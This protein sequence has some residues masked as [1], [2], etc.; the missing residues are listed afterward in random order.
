MSSKRY[1]GTCGLMI[2]K[3][4]AWDAH[5]RKMVFQDETLSAG[6][7][8]ERYSAVMQYTGVKDLNNQPIYEG[9]VCKVVEDYEKGTEIQTGVIRFKGGAFCFQDFALYEFPG[10]GTI[11]EIEIIGNKFENP[12]LIE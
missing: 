1:C 2:Q 12:E 4:R 3:F 7:M 11:C 5:L 9:D 10:D 6:K 8:L